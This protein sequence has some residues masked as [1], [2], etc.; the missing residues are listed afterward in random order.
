MSIT[1]CR[2]CLEVL[3]PYVDRELSQEE[4]VRVRAHLDECRGCLHLFEFEASVRRLVRVRCQ[5]QRAPE[6]LRQRVLARLAQERQ[7]LCD[8]PGE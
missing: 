1:A 6:A 4:I 3:H 8:A 2:T 5:E 7:R